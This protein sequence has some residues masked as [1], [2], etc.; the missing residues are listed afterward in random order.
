[1]AE[2]PKTA[3]EDPGGSEQTQYY[4]SGQTLGLTL[5][6]QKSSIYNWQFTVLK[7]NVFGS[8]NTHV[9]Y[10]I[11]ISCMYITI[12]FLIILNDFYSLYLLKF[13]VSLSSSKYD[14]DPNSHSFRRGCHRKVRPFVS[15]HTKCH[16]GIRWFDMIHVVHIDFFYGLEKKDK[17]YYWQLIII[18]LN[19]TYNKIRVML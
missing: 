14:I 6:F 2:R 19:T 18:S 8:K 11:S 3:Q 9:V 7:K 1:M 12:V 5:V 15:F 13:L 10:I 16:F 4:Q 17:N